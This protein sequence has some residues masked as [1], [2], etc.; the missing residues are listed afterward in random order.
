MRL[1]PLLPCCVLLIGCLSAATSLCRA[2]PAAA[3]A[4]EPGGQACEASIAEAQKQTATLPP[5]NPSRYFAER[6]LLQ[7]RSEAGNSEFDDCLE[8]ADRATREVKEQH[9]RLPPGVTLKVL[10]ADERP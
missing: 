9:H 7:A 6:D 4:P 10:R 1:T 8:W 5:A 3:A 2:D